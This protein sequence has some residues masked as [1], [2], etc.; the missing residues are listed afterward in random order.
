[1]K[2]VLFD[3]DDTLYDQVSLFE[4]AYN[5]LF[6]DRFKLSVEELFKASRRRSDEVFEPAR[7]GKITMN[8][9]Y[10]YRIQ[11]AFEDLGYEISSEEALEFQRLYAENQKRITISEMMADLL[12]LC[13][14]HHVPMGVIT[15]GPSGH[16]W[17]K[18]RMLGLSRWIPEEYTVVSDDCGCA[19]PDEG[20]FRF[21]QQKLNMS[22]EDLWFVG[23]SYSNDVIGAKKA[24]WHVVWLNK[25]NQD[26]SSEKIQPDYCVKN[27]AELCECLLGILGLKVTLH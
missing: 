6:G 14:Q 5:T 15:N 22:S 11:K 3:V 1:M 4:K 18:V 12:E 25:R 21:A 27:E 20:I 16:Q 23:D 17:N 8:E 9:M 13:N 2:A 10:I 24:G 19:K 7:S 26:I